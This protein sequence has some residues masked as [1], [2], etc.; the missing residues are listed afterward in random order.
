MRLIQH[1]AINQSSWVPVGV[2][3]QVCNLNG[4]DGR[5]PPGVEHAAEFDSTLGNV[6]D[7]DIVRI[8]LLISLS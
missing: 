6:P 2:G 8:G 3:P 5:A 7:P 4:V 1:R